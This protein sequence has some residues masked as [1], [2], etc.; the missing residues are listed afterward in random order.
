MASTGQATRTGGPEAPARP[1]PDARTRLGRRLFTDRLSRGVVILGG[2]LIIISILAILVVIAWEALPLFLKPTLVPAAAVDRG[3][4]APLAVGTEEYREILWIVSRS[5]LRLT[6]ASGTPYPAPLLPGSP[7]VTSVSERGRKGSL[8]LGLSVGSTAFLDLRFNANWTQGTRKLEPEFQVLPPMVLDPQGRPILHLSHAPGEKETVVAAA[9]EPGSVIVALR[10]KKKA[11]GGP[12]R[13][14]DS[15]VFLPLPAGEQV[16]ALLLDSRAEDLFVGTSRGIL[17]RVSVRDPEVPR[18]IEAVPVVPSGAAVTCLGFLLGDRTLVVGDAAGGV[19][20]WQL[21]RAGDSD[22]SLRKLHEFPSHDSSVAAIGASQR[23][24]GFVTGDQGGGIHV[25]Y[26][27]T[28]TLLLEG[29]IE[30]SLRAVT[31][32]PKGNGVLAAD[33]RGRISTWDLSNP[34][35]EITLGSLFGKVHYEGYESP[36]YVWQSTGTDDFEAKFGL[37]PLIYGTL[38]GTFYALLFAVPLALLSALYVSQFMSPALRNTVKP[39]VEVMA[40]L[41]SVVL[42]FI[43]GLWLAPRVERIIPGL[44]LLPVVTTALILAA[45]LGWRLA[46]ARWRRG[47]KP[48]SEIVL[49][50]P[51]VLLGIALSV[52]L[53]VLVEQSLLGGDFRVWVRRALGFTFDQKNSLVVGFAMGFAVIPIIFTISEDSLSNV[54][55]HLTAGSLA[56]GATRWQTAIRVVLPTASPGIFS[57]VMIGFGRAVGETMIVLMATGN[58]PVMNP[59]PFNGFRALSANV[60]VEL[61]E[62]AQGGTLFRVLFLAALLLFAM[63]FLVNTAAE[64]IRLR[65]RRRYQFL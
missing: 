63:T 3:P 40:A 8:A 5:G 32:A 52:L 47:L 51:V 20:T 60:A 46:P 35:P 4:E 43:A 6:S 41:P 38:K 2:V 58:T 64:L 25:C 7:H 13:V 54:P 26:G 12:E 10:K 34:H 62:A 30:G 61:P 28:G 16:R 36:D 19:R 15:R 57:A 56:L 1:L 49:L 59:S 37:T 23:D 27:T 21:I 33:A 31:L 44:F 48:G 55:A 24:K 11:L 39:V 18:V 14:V 9:V 65:L 45:L 50:I 29:R 17:L 42:G 53:G 22:F